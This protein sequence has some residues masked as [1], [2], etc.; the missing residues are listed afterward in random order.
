MTCQKGGG[1]Y[2]FLKNS[3]I[4]LKGRIMRVMVERELPSSGSFPQTTT[5]AG[6]EPS[7]SWESG[8]PSKS[9]S[10]VAGAETFGPS[11]TD[12][13]EISAGSGDSY[14]TL[15]L[16]ARSWLNLLCIVLVLPSFSTMRLHFVRSKCTWLKNDFLASLPDGSPCDVFWLMKYRKRFFGWISKMLFFFFTLL[17]SYPEIRYAHEW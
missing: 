15:A 7:Q 10:L 12:F 4:Y 14:G 13:P 17:S 2:F 1:H 11:F 16:Q 3:F 5:S 6:T 8:I 9:P